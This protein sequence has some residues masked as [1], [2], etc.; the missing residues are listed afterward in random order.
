MVHKISCGIGTDNIFVNH[1]FGASG[2]IDELPQ[3]G[4]ASD[5]PSSLGLLVQP[6][7]LL[8]REPESGL[9]QPLGVGDRR[10]ATAALPDRLLRHAS[11]YI[12]SQQ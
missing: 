2:F 10:A 5:P 3:D 9:H 8:R 12:G 7:N 4:V 6:F 1:L 11:I